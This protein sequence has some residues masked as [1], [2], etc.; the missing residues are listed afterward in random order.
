VSSYTQAEMEQKSGVLQVNRWFTK[1]VSPKL[2]V[3]EIAEHLTAKA[4][5][6]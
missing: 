2:L 3:Q 6:A 4:L 1:P 5:I